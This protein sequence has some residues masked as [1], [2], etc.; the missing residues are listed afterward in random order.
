MVSRVRTAVLADAARLGQVHT[1]A[2]QAAYRGLIPD[3]YLDSLDAQRAGDRWH[4]QLA[5]G[6]GGGRHVSPEGEAWVL[7]AE[8]DPGLIA[9]FAAV[10]PAR[11]Q[12]DD[13][14]G[15]LWAINLDPAMWSR[16]LGRVLL[17]AATGRLE[18]LGFSQAILW[19]LDTNDR[20]RRF[21][22]AAGWRPDGATKVD[23]E[24]GI[25]LREVRYTRDLARPSA[26][27]SQPCR[28]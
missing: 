27:A 17:A 25:P 21:Y 8:D 1:A 4:T 3:S 10:G 22:E 7:V 9:G 18:E 19:V 5:A 28:H 16:G 6:G 12:E 11:G 23:Q 20:A 15:E 14:I 26:P 13:A 2:W 24:R